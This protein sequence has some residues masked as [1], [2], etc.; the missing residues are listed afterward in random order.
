MRILFFLHRIGPYHHA[1]FSELAKKCELTVVEILPSSDEYEW[2]PLTVIS[3]YLRV[4]MKN[5]DK[6]EELRGYKLMKEV[7]NLVDAYQ[8]QAVIT[9]GWNNRTYMA[10]LFVAKKR[11]IPVF[12]MSDSTYDHVKRFKIIEF[13]KRL[14]VKSFDGFVTAGKRSEQYLHFLGVEK[15]F[16]F[17]PFDVVDN[18]HFK[19]VGDYLPDFDYSKPYILCVSRYIPEKNLFTL[20]DAYHLYLQKHPDENTLLYIIGSGPLE[21]L[22]RSKIEK[23]SHRL[24]C[25]LPFVQYEELPTLYHHAKGLILASTSEQWGLV[26]NEAMAAGIPVLVSNRCGCVD[27]LVFDGVNGWVMEPTL[28]GILNVLEKFFSTT[29]SRLKQMGKRGQDIISHFDLKDYTIAVLSMIERVKS[30]KIKWDAFQ[31]L[32]VFLRIFF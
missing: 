22:L 31:K 25:L 30:K 17:K 21:K 3:N 6:G 9:M 27:D 18:T 28:E 10:A 8:P 4:K 7:R 2:K 23:L 5:N 29:P 11:N 20:I 19:Q 12:A 24:I 16:I 32:I 15:S 1:R 13:I 26:V 14:L